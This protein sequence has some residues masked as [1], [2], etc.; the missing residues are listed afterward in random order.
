MGRAVWAMATMLWAGCGPGTLEVAD[1]VGTV[2]TTDDTPPTT[3]E[4]G[5][6]DTTTTGDTA[7]P[8]PA[9]DYV[10]Q[11]RAEAYRCRPP[12]DDL[13]LPWNWD[14]DLVVVSA[15]PEPIPGADEVAPC[16]VAIRRDEADARYPAVVGTEIDGVA[17]PNPGEP[18]HDA[19]LVQVYGWPLFLCG[20]GFADDWPGPVLL[21]DPVPLGATGTR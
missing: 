21:L 18:L 19:L 1:G 12:F 7:A 13:D 9:C 16:R 4:T 6:P 10:G 3:G 15:G 14:M 17:P 2:P 5:A 11:W 8:S 20:D